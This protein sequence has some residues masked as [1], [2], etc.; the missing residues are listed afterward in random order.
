M[1]TLIMKIALLTN[2]NK[3]W[4]LKETTTDNEIARDQAWDHVF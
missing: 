1:K 3:R 4:K 2:E